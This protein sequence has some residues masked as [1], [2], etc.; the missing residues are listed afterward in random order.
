LSLAPAD[1][2]AA[3]AAELATLALAGHEPAWDEL[4]RRHSHR[5]LVALLAHGVPLDAAEDLAQEAWLRLVEQQR[6]GR[7]A[8]LELPGLAIAQARWLAR[9]ADRTRAR[10]AALM[11][12][13]PAL[14]RALVEAPDLHPGADPESRAAGR[15]RLE[16]VRRALARCPERAQQVFHAVYAEHA[17]AHAEVARELGL[18]V[19]RVRQILCE[20]RARVR[21]ALGES[22]SEDER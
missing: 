21:A 20:V 4:V 22:E 18:S 10:R 5:V 6:A 19:Q 12:G 14:E 11:G 1:C 13:G 16:C 9:E 17:P 2:R 3:A 8:R 7:L 15:E